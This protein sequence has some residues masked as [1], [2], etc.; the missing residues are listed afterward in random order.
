MKAAFAAGFGFKLVCAGFE[1]NYSNPA[2][3]KTSKKEGAVALTAPFRGKP[4]LQ[5]F[6][7][8]SPQAKNS[9]LVERFKRGDFAVCGRRPKA[10]PL[11]TANL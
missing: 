7:S 6:P 3:F 4:L 1:F 2:L 5:A 9:P 8:F 10:P 11:E